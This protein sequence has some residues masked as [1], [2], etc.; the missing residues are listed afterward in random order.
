VK[1]SSRCKDF[2]IEALKYH[3]LKTDQKAIYKT[4]RTLPRTPLG[5][6]KVCEGKESNGFQ[7]QTK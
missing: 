3:L 5:L 7:I 2:L 6:P 1:T 4:P